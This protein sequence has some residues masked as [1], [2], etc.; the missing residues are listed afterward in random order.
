MSQDQSSWQSHVVN[1]QTWVRGLF[2]VL[3]AVIGYVVRLLVWALAALQFIVVIFR[4][5]PHQKL[6][7]LGDSLSQFCYQIM[8]Y[9]TFNSHDKPFP[10]G[11]WPESNGQPVAKSSKSKG[12]STEA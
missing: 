6:L 3:F 4:G 11:D 5:E 9:L 1:T 12:D 8:L 7:E 10:F 2:M